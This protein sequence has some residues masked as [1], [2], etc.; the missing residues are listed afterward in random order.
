M[1]PSKIPTIAAVLTLGSALLAAGCGRGG[2]QAENQEAKPQTPAQA[3]AAE[4]TPVR[5]APAVT[6][7]V[8]SAVPVTGSIT[9][10]QTVDL[11]PKI[12]ARIVRVAGR[13]GERVRRGQ[14]VVQQDTADLLTEVRRTEANLQAAQARVAQARTQARVQ[15]TQSSSGVEDA[16]QQLRAA[17]ARLELVKRPQ[18]TQEVAALENA[19]NQAQVR[20]EKAQLDRRRYEGLVKEG[21]VAQ[22]VVDQ[23]VTDEKIARVTL[24]TA[25]QNLDAAQTGGREESVRSAEAEVERARQAIRTAQANTQQVAVRED[26]IKAARATVTQSQ[27]S[28][29]FARQQLANAS[30]KSPID[31]VISERLTEPGQM[32]APG[33]LVLKVV[34]LDTVFFEAQVPETNIRSMRPGLN[35]AV[36]VDAYPGRSFTGKVAKIYPTASTQSRNFNVR[37][38]LPNTGR[39]LRPGLFA[40]GQVVTERRVGTVVSKDALVSREGKMLVFVASEDSKAE[41]RPVKVGVQTEQTAEV[42]SG[43][44][45]GER[46]IVAGQDT[47]ANG[48]AIRIQE[49]TGAQRAA[50]AQ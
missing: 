50:L 4:A 45:A 23:Y 20:L 25:R 34:A 28:L 8:S 2:E 32:A 40:R 18:R 36:R 17:E 10:L 19:V 42:L 49:E 27:A 11:S 38:V 26:E 16:R 31:G 37:I 3:A 9:A 12:T 30:I 47:L 21:A 33:A 39:L 13:E 41:L 1:K 24:D 7:A 5:V 48:A 46:V 15:V 44:R 22:S 29:A 14:V 35:V 6:R 43:V